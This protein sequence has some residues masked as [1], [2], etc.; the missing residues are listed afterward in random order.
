MPEDWP[1]K[2]IVVGPTSMKHLYGPPKSYGYIK[3]RVP[4][5]TLYESDLGRTNEGGDVEFYH[6]KAFPFTHRYVKEHDNY[7]GRVVKVPDIRKW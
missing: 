6:F 7:T 4:V 1:M 5:G 2:T 3:K